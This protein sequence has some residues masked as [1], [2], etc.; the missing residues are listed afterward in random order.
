MTRRLTIIGSILAA[1][2]FVITLTRPVDTASHWP[3]LASAAAGAAVMFFGIWFVAPL[4]AWIGSVA[5]L[6]LRRVLL[7]SIAPKE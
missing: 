3:P 6:R 7:R 5:L 1:I 2:V 4:F